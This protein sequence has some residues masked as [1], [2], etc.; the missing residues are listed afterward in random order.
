M[1]GRGADPDGSEGGGFNALGNT[2]TGG[3]QDI[4][5]L[6]PLLGTEQCE[7]HIGS[8]LSEGW[9]YVA[10]TPMSIFGSLGMARAGFKTLVAGWTS[11]RI[12]GSRKLKDTGFSP[13]GSNLSLIMLNQD[14]NKDQHLAETRL[15]S[16][17]GDLH[18][19]DARTLKLTTNVSSWNLYMFLS[20]AF[21]CILALAPYI[22]LNLKPTKASVNLPLA[23]R[24]LLPS[25]RALGGFL[26]ATMIQI[27]I[28]RRLVTIIRSRLIFMALDRQVK[29]AGL[30][31]DRDLLWEQGAASEACIWSLQQFFAD[32]PGMVTEE[33]KDWWEPAKKL[34]DE[35]KPKWRKETPATK[36]EGK[37][38]GKGEVKV[39][40]KEG[41]KESGSV[42]SRKSEEFIQSPTTDAFE[43][44]S[45]IEAQHPDTLPNATED[46][47]N[48]AMPRQILRRG[49]LAVLATRRGGAKTSLVSPASLPLP[50]SP[51]PAETDSDKGSIASG[52]IP[53]APYP[54]DITPPREIP[55]TV[56]LQSYHKTPAEEAATEHPPDGEEADKTDRGT[57]LTVKPKASWIT[58][59]KFWRS[60]QWKKRKKGTGMVPEDDEEELVYDAEA[61]AKIKANLDEAL[62]AHF[63]SF[64]PTSRIPLPVLSFLSAYGIRL[65]IPVYWPS[66]ILL[67]LG[68]LCSVV[69]Y[70]GCFTVVQ[71]VEN[72]AAPLIWLGL[73]GGLSI[74]RMIIWGWNPDN[75]S[76][77]R[78]Q[79]RLQLA[80]FP[81][82]PTC[83]KYRETIEHEQVL[84]LLRARV[85]LQGVTAYAGLLKR[86]D[87]LDISVF[88]TLTRSRD[89]SRVLFIT[90]FDYKERTTRI[91]SK[92]NGTAIIYAGT[93][94]EIDLEHDIMQTKMMLGRTV[95]QKVDPIASD[96]ELMTALSEH[97]DSILEKLQLRET[98]LSKDELVKVTWDLSEYA[99]ESPRPVIGPSQVTEKALVDDRSYLEEGEH[100]DDRRSLSTQRGE[101]ISQNMT[102]ATRSF[103][104]LL[105]IADLSKE[106]A[107]V[108]IYILITEWKWIEWLC[109]IEA[110]RCENMLQRKYDKMVDEVEQRRRHESATDLSEVVS[111]NVSEWMKR[112]WAKH[113]RIR[114]TQDKEKALGRLK[115]AADS[116]D[117]D[118]A[119]AIKQ[120]VDTKMIERLWKDVTDWIVKVW[121]QNISSTR[122]SDVGIVS[123][124]ELQEQERML[125][126]HWQSFMEYL[127]TAY[128]SAADPSIE[129]MM[130]ELRETDARVVALRSAN[131]ESEKSNLLHW[132][133]S[134][135]N[136]AEAWILDRLKKALVATDKESSTK[137]RVRKEKSLQRCRQ[138]F[139]RLK[140]SRATG[141]HR[142][143]QFGEVERF[144]CIFKGGRADS[145]QCSLASCHERRCLRGR[146][147]GDGSSNIQDKGRHVP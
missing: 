136:D 33:S 95:D 21:T 110:G 68:I 19:E 141:H 11:W 123:N 117:V 145:W 14:E 12:L 133:D 104:D 120:G 9:L 17:L 109:A 78:L 126:E 83:N 106:E 76:A 94:V 47:A 111:D 30:D 58:K 90:L 20:T 26:T 101:Q 61:L 69:G 115:A 127:I 98:T 88:Y 54:A 35:Y 52:S 44:A 139:T 143:V 140:E 13:S 112:E 27:V 128:S 32:R 31:R 146:P 41:S 77:P 16:M 57:A 119:N 40:G 118:F 28:Q 37:E 15:Q 6:L 42:K 108:A 46:V 130:Q 72:N 92:E 122:D 65:R 144:L 67:T 39:E 105:E 142:V 25:L 129:A 89:L 100:Q 62:H 7:S 80:A 97:H 36:A 87:N 147:N 50:E 99:R 66:Q 107:E 55:A 81:P 138:I 3:I 64:D 103:N 75:D 102:Y 85:F 134:G 131:E 49:A 93:P 45:S 4:S 114:L 10:A 29:D 1:S 84:P 82:L 63:P 135:E 43:H 56:R 121:E 18:I 59:F 113:A 137:F 23:V 73:E 74:I 34:W 38:D 53:S 116:L 96:L 79:F 22:H 60:W 86:F 51:P 24:W 124:S 5:A 125:E 71:S 48:K 8:A 132:L 2:L 70:L 91:Y